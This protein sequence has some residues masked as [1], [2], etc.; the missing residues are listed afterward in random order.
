LSADG[1]SARASAGEPSDDHGLAAIDLLLT[2][3]TGIPRQARAFTVSK[4]EAAGRMRISPAL[5]SRLE[6]LSLA[7]WRDGEMYFDILDL[8]NIQ[9]QLGGGQLTIGLLRL[10]PKMLNALPDPGPVAFEIGFGA[11][12]PEPSHQGSCDFS[13]VL[14]DG[15]CHQA[16][17]PPPHGDALAWMRLERPTRWPELPLAAKDIIDE[18]RSFR[19]A[20][21]PRRVRWDEIAFARKTG[22]TDCATFAQLFTE[23]GIRRGLSMRVSSGPLIAP[24][25]AVRHIWAEVEVDGVW[26]PTDPLLINTLVSRGRLDPESWPAHRSPGATFYPLPR[27][28]QPITCT[29]RGEPV[30]MIFRSRLVA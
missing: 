25:L 16:S 1:L 30:N 14:P 11:T 19:F 21:M 20:L 2:Q 9:Y 10:W 12:C 15:R 17:D 8:S 13:V 7:D 29:H 22:M 27:A 6:A 28:S 3:L 18:M 5:L 23:E 24:P 4:Q 26:V